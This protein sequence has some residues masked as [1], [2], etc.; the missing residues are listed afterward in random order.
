[1]ICMQFHQKIKKNLNFGLVKLVW[2]YFLSPRSG[3]SGA[4]GHRFIEPPELLVSKPVDSTVGHANEKMY[5]HC[6]AF[7]LI[8]NIAIDPSPVI[9]ST[10]MKLKKICYTDCKQ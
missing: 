8:Y 5:S 7:S 2:C 1:M 9:V 3:L 4:R 10:D 6:I